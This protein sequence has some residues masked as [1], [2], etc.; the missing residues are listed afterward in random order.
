MADERNDASGEAS[1]TA[2][3]PEQPE[4][5]V[6]PTDVK[7]QRDDFY[8]RLLRKTAALGALEGLSF[9]TMVL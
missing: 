4:T 2:Q 3:Q 8:D 7:Q 6:D 1:A 9:E 5:S